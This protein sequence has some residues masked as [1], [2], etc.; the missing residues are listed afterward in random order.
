MAEVTAAV[1]EVTVVLVAATPVDSLAMVA[2]AADMSAPAEAISA[3]G[4]SAVGSIPAPAFL[5]A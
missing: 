1:A 4:A 2:S 3:A 5:P